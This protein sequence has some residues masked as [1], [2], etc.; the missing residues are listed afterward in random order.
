VLVLLEDA[1]VDVED[2]PALRRG[3]RVAGIDLAR[4][5]DLHRAGPALVGG[6]LLPARQGVA[7]HL[8]H[9]LRV[10]VVAGGPQLPRRR[11][12]G[13]PLPRAA[14]GTL[15][16]ALVGHLAEEGALV[17]VPAALI[18]VVPGHGD[19]RLFGQADDLGVGEGERTARD[20]VVSG[21]AERVPVHLPQQDRLALRRRLPA[22]IPQAGARGGARGGRP[23]CPPR[24]PAGPARAAARA[25]RQRSAR[26]P[27][28]CPPGLASRGPE[29]AL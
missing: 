5:G 24:P 3:A 19:E 23:I 26:P 22:R 10:L 6:E 12:A 16:R 4:V 28:R 20:A 18:P 29:R 21:T 7:Q 1:G 9:D 17:V 13:D 25:D 15:A 27:E 8:E 11:Q 14:A 2:E